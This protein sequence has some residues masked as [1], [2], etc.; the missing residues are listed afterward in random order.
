MQIVWTNPGPTS[1]YRDLI[2]VGTPYN[3]S[4]GYHRH[5]GAFLVDSC[6]DFDLANVRWTDKAREGASCGTFFF[7]D[8]R[9]VICGRVCGVVRGGRGAIIHYHRRASGVNLIRLFVFSFCE[10]LSEGG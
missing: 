9:Y 1:V 3:R 10:T 6:F 7:Y 4:D 5:T 2:V 8:T